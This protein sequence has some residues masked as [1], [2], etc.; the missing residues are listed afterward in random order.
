M[1]KSV[2]L[3]QK[4]SIKAGDVV[5]YHPVIGGQDDG[6]DYTVTEVGVIGGGR[7]VA[8]LNGKS[9]CVSLAALSSSAIATCLDDADLSRL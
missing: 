8:W 2:L 4:N 9:G 5:R 1:N 6:R 7:M 3:Q